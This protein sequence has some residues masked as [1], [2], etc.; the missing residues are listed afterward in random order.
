MG[1]SETSGSIGKMENAEEVAAL[2][3]SLF[4]LHEDCVQCSFITRHHHLIIL[5]SSWWHFF[6]YL[7]DKLK[8]S[9][10][11]NSN[12]FIFSS[13]NI[14]IL[15]LF[16]SPNF[17]SMKEKNVI[18]VIVFYLQ[19]PATLNSQLCA[20]SSSLNYLSWSLIFHFFHLYKYHFGF[21][22]SPFGP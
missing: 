10:C 15:A 9:T 20:S 12:L 2:I 21:I 11:F 6:R 22:S 1:W 17:L 19:S 8:P 14:G 4:F 16:H 13:I 5:F 7:N 18:N 3:G